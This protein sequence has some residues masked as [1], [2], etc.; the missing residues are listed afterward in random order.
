[1]VGVTFL[2]SFDYDSEFDSLII[3]LL[4]AEEVEGI[5]IRGELSIMALRATISERYKE[6]LIGFIPEVI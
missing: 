1:M 6:L 4:T 3:R 5:A 2:E